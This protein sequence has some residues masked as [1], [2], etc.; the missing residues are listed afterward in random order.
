MTCAVELSCGCCRCSFGGER[1][2]DVEFV[3]DR[4]L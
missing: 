2:C 1:T 3:V 4:S